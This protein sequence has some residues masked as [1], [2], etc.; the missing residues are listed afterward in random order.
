MNSKKLLN[1]ALIALLLTGCSSSSSTTTSNNE[2]PVETEEA[3]IFQEQTIVENESC[4][5]ILKEVDEDGMW[6][7][8]WKLYLEN[9]TDKNLMFSMENVSVNGV[10]ADPFWASEVASGKSANET[11]TWMSTTLEENSIQADSVTQVTFTLNVYDNDDWMADR[12]V[13]QEFTIYP[14]GEEAATTVEQTTS[15]SDIVL[16]DNDSVTLTVI[17]FDEN[18]IYG[19]EMKMR[20]VNKTD[21]NIM[22]SADNVSIDNVMCDP[23]WADTISAGKTANETIT[24]MST[25]LEE[26]GLD[27]NSISTIELPVTVYDADNWTGENILEETYTISIT[28]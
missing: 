6:G 27:K 12:I 20:V 9:K 24:W 4:S 23:F 2:K 28:H 11:V 10:M 21:K 15:E 7:Y 18:S 16:V 14:K 5:V 25:T 26:S 17:G 1:C 8:D 13:E 3:V 22:V 19:F